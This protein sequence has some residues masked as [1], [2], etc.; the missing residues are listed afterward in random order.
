[1]SLMSPSEHLLGSG[2]IIIIIEGAESIA[3]F[4]FQTLAKAIKL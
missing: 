3:Q 1:M 2:T 4:V